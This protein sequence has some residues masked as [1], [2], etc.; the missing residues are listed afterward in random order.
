MK[1]TTVF[2]IPSRHIFVGQQSGT[3]LLPDDK[4]L[5]DKDYFLTEFL[6]F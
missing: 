5:L 2:C 3:N 6:F 1:S 4:N